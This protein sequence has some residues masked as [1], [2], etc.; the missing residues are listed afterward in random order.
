LQPWSVFVVGELLAR[1]RGPDGIVGAI[2]VGLLAIFLIVGVFLF[3]IDTVGE[4]LSLK[5]PKLK[6][7]SENCGFERVAALLAK[8]KP[9]PS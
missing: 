2:I 7:Q 4:P 9:V 5:Q 6:R 3:Q 1:Q 8:P